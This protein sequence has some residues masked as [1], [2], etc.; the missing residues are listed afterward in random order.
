MNT[1]GI[2][3]GRQHESE[4][5]K[6]RLSIFYFIEGEE[7]KISE[8]GNLLKEDHIEV[9]EDRKAFKVN[10]V[11]IACQNGYFVDKKYKAFGQDLTVRHVGRGRAK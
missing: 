6:A 9:Y 4:I 11:K 2:N 7:E 8:A 1:L 10:Q 3:Q 5:G